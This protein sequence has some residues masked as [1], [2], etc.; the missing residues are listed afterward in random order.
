MPRLSWSPNT[1]TVGRVSESPHAIEP[2][3]VT[4]RSKRVRVNRSTQ[5]RSGADHLDVAAAVAGHCGSAEQNAE[6]CVVEGADR[7]EIDDQCD[8]GMLT[9]RTRQIVVEAA[10]RRQVDDAVDRHHDGTADGVDTSMDLH[11]RSG[12]GR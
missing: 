11:A 8:A 2:R 3:T 6:T 7:I 10:D 12:Y 5:R 9:N 1:H 4:A